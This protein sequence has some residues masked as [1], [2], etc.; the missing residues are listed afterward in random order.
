MQRLVFAE[1]LSGT[2]ASVNTLLPS[3]LGS[4]S[5][6]LSLFDPF[7]EKTY[8]TNTLDFEASANEAS[9]GTS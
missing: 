3:R 8:T 2:C 9:A 5:F 6:T 4:G 7:T 1:D